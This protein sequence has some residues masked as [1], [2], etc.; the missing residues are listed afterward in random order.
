MPNREWAFH[1]LFSAWYKSRKYESR[2][3][4]SAAM[5]SSKN[6]KASNVLALYKAKEPGVLHLDSNQKRIERIRVLDMKEKRMERERE[7]EKSQKSLLLFIRW[8]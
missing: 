1:L 2:L 6:G 8:L 4:D 7:R 3:Y 5:H